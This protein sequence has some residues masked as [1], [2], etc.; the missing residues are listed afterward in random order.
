[1]QLYPGT[2][3]VQLS[4]EW[5]IPNDALV[6]DPSEYGGRVRIYIAKCRFMGR[7]AWILR[8]EAN[9][10]GEGDHPRSIVEIASDLPLRTT[11]GLE[12]GMNVLLE[13]P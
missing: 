9:E 6:L 5:S 2:L 4:Q 3:N 12:D 10:R 1:M 11:F 7:N 13:L 8:T